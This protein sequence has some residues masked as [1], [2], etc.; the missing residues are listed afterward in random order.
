MNGSNQNGRNLN[1]NSGN[2]NPVN[3]NN[4]A[5]GFA[6]R[7]VAFPSTRINRIRQVLFQTTRKIDKPKICLT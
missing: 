7:P 2:V 5:N 3:N 4:R 6:V 1:F